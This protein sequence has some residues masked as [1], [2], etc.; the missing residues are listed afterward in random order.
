MSV[1]EAKPPVEVEI[2]WLGDFRLSARAG[3]R[4]TILDGDGRAGF[5][6]VQAL[7]SAVAGCMAV[8]VV[9]IL[10]KGRQPLTGLR[11]R[12]EARRAGKDPRRVIAVTLRFQV[13]G[14]VP[15]EKV[16]RAIL[17]SRETYCSV[18]HSLQP[19]IELTTSFEI[20]RR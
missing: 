16:E 8:D 5:S 18:W 13:E 10:E 12:A 4:E 15:P 7:V 19:D 14:D 9:H 20:A 3:Q 17:L 11:V 2:E 6:P 1:P